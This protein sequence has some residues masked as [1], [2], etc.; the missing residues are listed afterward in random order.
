MTSLQKFSF[1]FSYNISIY[2]KQHTSTL[3]IEIQ[4]FENIDMTLNKK[5]YILSKNEL[6]III[7]IEET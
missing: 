2:E 6:I 7:N 5:E 3:Y 1:S 4:G